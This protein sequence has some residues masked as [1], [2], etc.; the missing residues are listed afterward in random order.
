MNMMPKDDALG[1]HNAAGRVQIMSQQLCQFPI[2]MIS[3]NC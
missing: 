1:K 3:I 2:N